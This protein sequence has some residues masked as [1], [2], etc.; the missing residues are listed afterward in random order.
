VFSWPSLLLLCCSVREYHSPCSFVDISIAHKVDNPFGQ[1]V[2]R[3]YFEKKIIFDTLCLM[4]CAAARAVFFSS[5]IAEKL[6]FHPL[7]SLYENL[8][9]VYGHFMRFNSRFFRFFTSH[10]YG[11]CLCQFESRDHWMMIFLFVLLYCSS[12]L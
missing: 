4:S 5:V 7:Y 6:T 2:S 12:F 8:D 3:F 10:L 11:G 1:F 9:C